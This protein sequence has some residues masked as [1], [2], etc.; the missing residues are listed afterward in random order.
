MR[1]SVSD[2][3]YSIIKGIIFFTHAIT[4]TTRRR[5]NETMTSEQIYYEDY[6]NESTMACT[7]LRF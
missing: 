3:E 6:Q 1:T 2:V 7:L 5:E 4:S